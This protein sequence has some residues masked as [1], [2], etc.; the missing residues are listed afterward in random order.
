MRLPN[1][2]TSI[3][4]FASINPTLKRAIYPSG[5]G[6]SC[7]TLCLFRYT[8]G[9]QACLPLLTIPYGHVAY[10]YCLAYHKAEYAQ[11]LY[12][13]GIIDDITP[14]PIPSATRL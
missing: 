1:Q 12:G 4:S 7:P 11:C 9:S 8:F 6:V 10:S 2:S 14:G 3:R 13:C 5:F